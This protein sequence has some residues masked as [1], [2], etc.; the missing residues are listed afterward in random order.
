MYLSC[1]SIRHACVSL[2]E[3]VKKHLCGLVHLRLCVCKRC[4]HFRLCP[5]HHFGSLRMVGQ[6]TTGCWWV[7]L[8][9]KLTDRHHIGTVSSP[10]HL[11]GTKYTV[12]DRRFNAFNAF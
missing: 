7:G 8:R 5:A 10:E 6:D 9:K 12:G 11:F 3:C 4:V 1:S 2:Y